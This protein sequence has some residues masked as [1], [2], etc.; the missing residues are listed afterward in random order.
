MFKLL[1]KAKQKYTLYRV[2]TKIFI[3]ISFYKFRK[4]KV[5]IVIEQNYAGFFAQ[6]T[7]F[8]YLVYYCKSS[9][10]SPMIYLR[11]NRYNTGAEL[12]NDILSSRFDTNWR[13]ESLEDS[14]VI[15]VKHPKHLPMFLA[16]VKKMNLADEISIISEYL[17]P[18]LR[19]E[20]IVSDFISKKK[21]ESYLSIHIRGTDKYLEAP[22]VST[23][24]FFMEIG[25]HLDLTTR[26]KL[27]IFIA[28]DSSYE[29]GKLTEL[30][31]SQFPN[32][33]TISTNSIRS[34]KDT[35]ILYDR[36]FAI[37]DQISLGD[38]ALID[39]IL[40]SKGQV[41]IRNSS[42]LSNFSLY[43]NRT[44][45][46]INLNI[47]YSSQKGFPNLCGSPNQYRHFV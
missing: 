15:T 10:I 33:R 8:V 20:E 13:N 18:S 14:E 19:I 38:E 40:L 44:L 23:N 36:S 39:C 47:P 2:R 26:E 32:I 25:K 5:A 16:K 24:E 27:D 31:S 9:G 4:K 21:L 22:S 6:L 42:Y 30:I 7:W 28:S 41:L 35:S 11:D 45:K 37:S 17:K 3:Q 34:P 12:Q 46:V 29:L 1:R 43:F